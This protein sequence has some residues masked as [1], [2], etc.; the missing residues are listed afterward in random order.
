MEN[1]LSLTHTH[2]HN[3]NNKKANKQTLIVIFL[4]KYFSV[5]AIQFMKIKSTFPQFK[6]FFLF[7]FC[8]VT[9]MNFVL[10]YKL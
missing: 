7:F 1:S 2:T 4:L 10:V 8:F 3:N 9:G 5:H 6:C